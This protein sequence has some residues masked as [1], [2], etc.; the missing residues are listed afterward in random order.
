M[1]V[2]PNSLL[3]AIALGGP[4]ATATASSVSVTASGAGLGSFFVDSNKGVVEKEHPTLELVKTF[5]NNNPVALTFTVSHSEPTGPSYDLYDV[6]EAINNDTTSTFTNFHLQITEPVGVPAHGVAFRSFNLPLSSFAP[7]FTPSFALDSPAKEQPSPFQH[8]GPRDLN[9]TGELKA[10]S[11]TVDSYFSLTIPD[12]GA[13]NTYT[14]TLSQ[15]P[16]VVPEPETYALMLAGLGL[17]G[18]MARRKKPNA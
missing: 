1:K 6:F 3:L 8:T 12:P 17:V 14:F 2:L 7:N 10:G 9:F 11:T 16:T 4:I 18:F 13:G 15:T 5:S